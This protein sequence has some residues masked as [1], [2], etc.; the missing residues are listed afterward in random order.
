MTGD[1][2]RDLTFPWQPYFDRNVFQT[3]NLVAFF[4]SLVRFMMC[5]FVLITLES[6]L[7]DFLRFWT[8]PEIQ[9]GGRRW[10]P[11]RNNYTIITSCDVIAS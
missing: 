4:K 1:C 10:P 7:G 9:D 11:F 3:F 5:L 2:P 6:I 8:N